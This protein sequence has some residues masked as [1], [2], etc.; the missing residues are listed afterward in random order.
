MV[1]EMGKKIIYEKDFKLRNELEEW[2]EV[3][4]ISVTSCYSLPKLKLIKEKSKEEELIIFIRQ[5]DSDF[6]KIQGDFSQVCILNEN[7][8]IDLKN[9]IFEINGSLKISNQAG[10]YQFDLICIGSSTGGLPVIQKVFKELKQ[11][12]TIIILCQHIGADHSLNIVES[13]SKHIKHRM[14][15]VEK[16]TELIKGNT[17]ILS[18]SSDFEIRNKYNKL[19]LEPVGITTESYHPSFN[20]LTGSL[21]KLNGIKMGCIILSGL[22]DDGSKHL[23]DLKNKKVKILV[24][25]PNSAVAPF[26]PRAAITTGQVDHIYD[27]VQLQD[28]L[29]R[30]AA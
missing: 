6:E 15:F 18:G 4:G 24:Q 16:S 9:K 12:K 29:K 22:G 1:K 3:E 2:F 20:V 23:K 13:L 8:L 17:Y 26:M 14:R 7:P 5:Q 10:R 21:T 11:K 19:F 27:E 25:D 30:S 28:F